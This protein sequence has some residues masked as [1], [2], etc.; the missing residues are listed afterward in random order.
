MAWFLSSYLL[1]LFVCINILRGCS[2]KGKRYRLQEQWYH[3]LMPTPSPMFQILADVSHHYSASVRILTFAAS[4]SLQGGWQRPFLS[5]HFQI[6]GHAKNT[7]DWLDISGCLPYSSF[8][9][10]TNWFPGDSF[11]PSFL[12]N[13]DW[14]RF[15]SF[16]FEDITE[17]D[18]SNFSSLLYKRFIHYSQTSMAIPSH[19]ETNWR[20]ECLEGRGDPK[21]LYCFLKRILNTWSYFY[22][23]HTPWY[24]KGIII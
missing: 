1:S 5:C 13:Q 4:F 15:K 8:H 16:S 21:V 18:I 3:T 14:E 2:T 20:S 22:Y 7:H 10:I 6:H 24:W 12:T 23:Y 9:R 17:T 19:L 11:S